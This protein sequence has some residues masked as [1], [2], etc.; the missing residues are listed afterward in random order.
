MYHPYLLLKTDLNEKYNFLK[1]EVKHINESYEYKHHFY[2]W[3]C[4]EKY[5]LKG[6]PI[7]SIE[8]NNILLFINTNIAP[9]ID[10]YS[11]NTEKYKTLFVYVRI[12]IGMMNKLVT[13]NIITPEQNKL[14]VDTF[15]NNLW[16][17]IHEWQNY[18]MKYIL[19]IPF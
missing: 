10:F 13:N 6:N 1:S 15:H 19:K 14:L 11:E 2:D 4:I 9:N 17:A 16:E 3:K 18:K 5:V 12:V 8:L 7:A